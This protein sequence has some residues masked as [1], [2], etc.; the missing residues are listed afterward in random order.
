[1]NNNIIPSGP[2]P[3]TQE[4]LLL[5]SEAD[6]G[7][8]RT[9]SIKE[10]TLAEF[11]DT[12]RKGLLAVS[13]MDSFLGGLVRSVK[14]DEASSFVL[15]QEIDVT[16]VV[17]FIRSLSETLKFSASSL[18]S[19]HVNLALA[20]RDSVLTKSQVLKKAPSTQASLRTLP[21]SSS[22]LFGGDH[23]A[24]TIH[25]LA[26]ARRDMAFALPRMPAAKTSSQGQGSN[27]SSFLSDRGSSGRKFQSVH[28]KRGGKSVKKTAKSNKPYERQQASKVQA[29]PSPQ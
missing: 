16:D 10:K 13:A 21:L 11:E 23:V 18:A 7:A 20:R 19:L 24:P 8:G 17:S 25:S 28:E 4:D 1:M 12:A 14:D 6:R 27:R 2:L 22:A 9:V 29:K 5:L 15:K 26:E 3:V